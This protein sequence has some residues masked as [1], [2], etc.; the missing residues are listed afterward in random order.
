MHVAGPIELQAILAAE[1]RALRPGSDFAS[2]ST[3]E[4]FSLVHQDPHGFSALCIS[5]GGIRSATFALGAIQSLARHGL[6]ERFDYLS[7]V[8][9]GGYIGAWLTAWSHRAGGL[10]AIIP[11]LRPDAKPA[12]PGA[13]D[14]VAHLRDYNNYLSPRLG[15]MSAD[16]WT[17]VATILTNLLLNWLVLLPL[18]MAALMVPRLFLSVLVFP[19]L[20]FGAFI[21][22]GAPPAPANYGAIELDAVSGSLAVHYGLP[23]LSGGLF[24]IG[25]FNTLRYLPGGGNVDHT[26]GDYMAGVL[27]PLVGAVLLYI[28]FDSLYYLGSTYTVQGSLIR[29]ILA[30]LLPSAAAWLAYRLANRNSQQAHHIASALPLG[31]FFMAASTGTASWAAANFLLWSP[32]PD[33]AVSWPVYVTVAPVT[34]L[35]GY[36]LGTVLFVG[37]SSHVLK[38]ADREWLSRSVAGM[39]L[40]CAAWLLACGTVL[41]AP[42]WAFDWDSW[43][44]WILAA[45]VTISGWASAFGGA[46]LARN[47]PAGPDSRGTGWSAA[48]LV[49]LFAPTVFVTALAIGLAM[50]TNLLLSVLHLVPGLGAL[51]G[52]QVLA[53]DGT[54]VPWDDHYAVLDR[55]ST[56]VVATLCIGLLALSRVLARFVNINTFSLH[57][58]YRDRLVR[59]YLGASNPKRNASK[60]TG[61]APDDDFSIHTLSP[62]QRPLHVINLTLNLV[63]ASRLAWQQRKAQSFTVSALHCGNFNLGYRASSHYGGRNGITLGTAI[64]ISGAAASPNMGHYSSR[65]VGFIMTLLNARLGSWLGNPGPAGAD[66]WQF[67]GPRSAVQSLVKEALGLTSNQN[68]YVYLSDGGHFENLGLYEMVLRR[69]RTIVVLDAG[70]DPG[71]EL[72]GLGD[73]LRKIRIDHGIPI[74]FDDA[75]MRALRA[76]QSRCTVATI[77]YSAVDAGAPDGRLIYLKPV[78]LG[79]EPA[80]VGSYGCTHPEFPH[81]STANQWFDESQTESYPMLGQQTVDDLCQNWRGGSLQAFARHLE[82]ANALVG[83]ANPAVTPVQTPR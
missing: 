78:L 73:A 80:D 11:N 13:P 60:F 45:V 29:Q 12:A 75:S 76:R 10:A 39:L 26:R 2:R 28:A 52:M 21:F 31:I 68:P 74:T 4:L 79:N 3:T 14:P 42:Q 25:F 15:A 71:F 43:V 20:M 44:P 57:G 17:L 18:L 19:E 49:V 64:A 70:G 23:L 53:V 83:P 30:A 8:S 72:E 41:I 24:A 66:T 51:P 35:L 33:T 55:S 5:G 82:Q 34:I 77:A 6:L 36:V 65:M 50:A 54:A 22:A 27:L 67:A 32:N 46:L 47:A 56:L 61:F 69:C 63:Q 1:Y 58:M 37:L 40:F 7:T 81:Q 9:G 59:A 48:A 62:Q 38:D 16:S